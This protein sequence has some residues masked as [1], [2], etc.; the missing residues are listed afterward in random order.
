MIHF[1]ELA[2]LDTNQYTRLLRRAEVAID[3]LLE[4]VRPIVHAIKER[5]DEALIEFTARF[6]KVALTPERQR[7][8][9]AEIE[10]A[11]Q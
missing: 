5:G 7:E 1:Y 8:E 10:R 11:H 3:E 4:Y 9:A 2:R 6:D